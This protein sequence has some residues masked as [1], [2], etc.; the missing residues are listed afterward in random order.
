MNENF[1]FFGFGCNSKFNLK[2]PFKI[3]GLPNPNRKRP[4]SLIYNDGLIDHRW[5]LDLEKMLNQL[6]CTKSHFV[7]SN[8]S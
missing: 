3:K 2:K 4:K 8:K 7:V 5:N 6:K 1:G